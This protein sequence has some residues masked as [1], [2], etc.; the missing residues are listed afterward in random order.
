MTKQIIN[1]ETIA[2]KDG[3][4]VNYPEGEGRNY[5]VGRIQCE[6][7][8]TFVVNKSR[9]VEVKRGSRI[10]ICYSEDIDFRYYIVR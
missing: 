6:E 4:T 7:G 5:F 1:L 10:G 9:R 8:T 3:I 2:K